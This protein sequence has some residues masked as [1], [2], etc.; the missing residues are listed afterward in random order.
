MNK[1]TKASLCDAILLHCIFFTLK[2]KIKLQSPE[3]YCKRQAKSSKR[4]YTD[5]YMVM[6]ELSSFFAEYS[7]VGNI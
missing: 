3:I 4:C 1:I 2:K 7:E 5:E 6:C